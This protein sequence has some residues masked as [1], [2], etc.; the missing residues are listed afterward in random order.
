MIKYSAVYISPIDDIEG[1][2]CLCKVEQLI[3]EKQGKVFPCL[4]SYPTRLFKKNFHGTLTMFCKDNVE[5]KDTQEILENFDI[6]LS[7]AMSVNFTNYEC[8]AS[9]GNLYNLADNYFCKHNATTWLR[10]KEDLDRYDSFYIQFVIERKTGRI[11]DITLYINPSSGVAY[12]HRLIK[13][14]FPADKK[15]LSE[16]GHKVQVKSASSSEK[17]TQLEIDKIL[18]EHEALTD[19]TIDVL[20]T[21]LYE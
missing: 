10:M 5:L 11:I 18:R 4:Y 20:T 14:L 8:Y 16:I 13:G 19:S 1:D 3:G 9:D 12:N 2:E 17:L 7:Y 15:L 6:R 21:V